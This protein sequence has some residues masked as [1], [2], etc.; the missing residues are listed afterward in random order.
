MRYKNILD[1]DGSV[2][3]AVKYKNQ[4]HAYKTERWTNKNY[5]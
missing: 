4:D 5:T 1:L 2:T 3:I